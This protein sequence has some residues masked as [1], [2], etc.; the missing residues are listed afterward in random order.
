MPK[1]AKGKNIKWKITLP[2]D[3]AGRVELQLMDRE[4][5]IPVYGLRSKLIREL[6]QDWIANTPTPEEPVH[7]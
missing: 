1:L 4:R 3:L 6:L 5:G 7:E 2:L